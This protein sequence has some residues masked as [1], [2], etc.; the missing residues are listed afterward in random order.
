M[1][2]SNLDIK[3]RLRVLKYTLDGT[4]VEEVVN[5]NDITV[6]GRRLVANLFMNKSGENVKSISHMKLGR[7]KD[8]F[9][10]EDK[11]LKDV[12]NT[13]IMFKN[14]DSVSG[15]VVDNRIMVRYIGEIEKDQCNDALCEAGLFTEE[16]IMY[17][18]VIFDPITKS[19]Q[20]KLT[21]IW[22]ITF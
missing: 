9:N 19:E 21:L 10:P 18:R 13:K 16:G 1:L 12:I 8:A 3:G 7:S 20:F 11:N 5:H 14:K 22:E 17:N 2:K 15:E 4:F 6:E